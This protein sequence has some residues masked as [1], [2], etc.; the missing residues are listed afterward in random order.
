MLGPREEQHIKE[1]VDIWP[2]SFDAARTPTSHAGV[3]DSVSDS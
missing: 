3:P 1:G 2:C